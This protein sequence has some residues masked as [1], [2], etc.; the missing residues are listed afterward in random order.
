MCLLLPL[1][2]LPLPPLLLPAGLHQ[3]QGFRASGLRLPRCSYVCYCLQVFTF[4]TDVKVAQREGGSHLG[5]GGGRG[6]EMC[7]LPAT[8]SARELHTVTHGNPGSPTPGV[9]AGRKVG[10][11]LWGFGGGPETLA[12]PPRGSGPA[13]R[14]VGGFRVWGGGPETLARPPQGSGPVVR[15]EGGLGFGGP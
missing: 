5:V 3:C 12:R 7:I 9:R 11:G 10:W 1:L 4:F 8:D 13:G 15:G 2:L 6:M 14:W